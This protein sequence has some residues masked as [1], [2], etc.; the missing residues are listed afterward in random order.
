MRAYKRSGDGDWLPPVIYRF[1]DSKDS[2]NHPRDC[3]AI[4]QT[5]L[6]N[7]TVLVL[8]EAEKKLVE[9][10]V[11]AVIAE[12]TQEWSTRPLANH[13]EGMAFVPFEVLVEH[14]FQDGEGNFL[15]G[16]T[17]E[18]HGLVLLSQQSQGTIFA[19]ELLQDGTLREAGRYDGPL[20]DTRALELDRRSGV[21]YAL[22]GK[23]F[24]ALQLSSS[25]S[26]D[27]RS[28]EVLLH[29]PS[30]GPD[31]IEGLALSAPAEGDAWM[32]ITDDEN[33]DGNRAVL[34]YSEFRPVHEPN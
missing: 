9:Y 23:D 5:S 24:A 14:G 7:E 27:G 28:F 30:P 17:L 12:K 4:T 21:L 3:E 22:D 10:D 20:K 32:I 13:L 11:S 1:E 25:K 8:F 34:L 16:R 26:T 31:D 18:K 19:A 29:T 15:D 6:V 2:G 33:P